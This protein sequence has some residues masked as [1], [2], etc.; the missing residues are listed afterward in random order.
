[1]V[2]NAKLNRRRF[3]I[4]TAAVGG[5]MVMNVS[6]AD[7][8]NGR[9]AASAN[10]AR[11]QGGV[12]M[13]ARL[14]INPDD[15]ITVR[16]TKP[17]AGQG[18]STTLAVFV[19]EELGSDP[20]DES[21]VHIE[22]ADPRRDVIENNVYLGEMDSFHT[23]FYGRADYVRF[24]YQQAGASAR[25][26]LKEAAATELGVP[27][28]ELT[29]SN[30]KVHHEA[31]G[32]SL[33][34][35]VLAEAAAQVQ[36]AEEPSIRGP[37]EWQLI[38]KPHRKQ[39][40]PK[41]VSGRAEFGMDVHLPDMLYGAVAQT[42]IIN[43]TLKSYDAEAAMSMP[44]VHSI[45]PL[46]EFAPSTFI[47]LADSYWHARKGLEAASLE[48][49]GGEADLNIEDIEAAHSA[50]LD[51]PGVVADEEGDA[52]AVLETADHVFEAVYKTPY[53]QHAVMEPRN[54]TA[55]FTEDRVDIWNGA[56]TLDSASKIVNMALG[57][58]PEIIH[59]HPVYVGGAF[60]GGRGG[61]DVA[62]AVIAAQ[63]V[64]GRPVKLVWSREEHTRTGN[65]D[66][67]GMAKLQMSVDEDG[68]PEAFF[69]RKA[70]QDWESTTTPFPPDTFDNVGVRWMARQTNLANPTIFAPDLPEE[71]LAELQANYYDGLAYRVPNH[72]V[73]YNDVRTPL[74]VIAMRSPGLSSNVFMVESFIDEVAHGVGKD[75][76]E[77]RY[78]LLRQSA[79][80]EPGWYTVLD[81]V[82]EKANWG[83]ALPKGS[84]Q[85][86]AICAE[87]GT[88]IAA[89]AEVTVSQEGDLT[90]DQVD[91]AFDAG[92]IL[93]P[94]GARNQLEGSTLFGWSMALNEEI[95]VQNGQL[96]EDNF[97][98]YL[99]AKAADAPRKL[100]IH[101]EAT[102]DY[103]PDAALGEATVPHMAAAVGNAIF[104]ATGKR[105]RSLPFRKADLSWS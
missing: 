57:V 38:G 77:L 65:L 78:W 12:E 40:T 13:A 30:N 24:L 35:G 74:P 37:E 54:A 94:D 46:A 53:R 11:Q 29:V 87:H 79:E 63:T 60:G 91:V 25:E 20:L 83:K 98:R 96:V 2:T 61:A 1:M 105:V 28:S 14:V 82:A 34:F 3:V 72:R 59:H 88:I 100:N 99:L 22:W 76:L 70:N 9:N 102:S 31:S 80:Q 92:Y 49:E 42:P 10:T 18:T 90:I 17:E 19:C 101:F 6:A 39:E 44:G 47:V 104:A 64:P 27:A 68:W 36:L 51:E 16:S 66:P 93:N 21:M 75:P 67:F 45:V 89:I 43:G 86:L 95:T 48:W 7:R 52:L 26:R 4:G 73:E 56:G 32:R 97:D 33:G 55:I 15:S 71:K 58:P 103:R 8:K 85:G 5:A 41:K 23:Y 50:M 81:L 69:I 62:L 84:G